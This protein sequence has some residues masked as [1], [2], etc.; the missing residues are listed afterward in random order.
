MTLVWPYTRAVLTN[1]ALWFWGVVFMAF[2]F[3]LGAYVFSG[4]LSPGH[5][6]EVA[7]TSAWFAVIALFSL[8]TLA[9]SMASSITYGTSALAFGFR[10]TRLTPARYTFALIVASAVM[11]VL[12]SFIMATAV[13]GLFSAHFGSMILPVDLPAIVG[14]A[15][16]SG[17]FMMGLATTLV[18]V[19]VNYLGLRNMNFIEFFPLILAY[20]FGFTQLF[21]SVPAWVLYLSPWNDMESLLYQAFSGSPARVVLGTATSPVLSWGVSAGALAAWVAVLVG[22]A[23]LLLARIHSVSI[24]EG[25]QI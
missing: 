7:Y 4:G 15:V 21:L 13:S 12:L 14:V 1:P 24:Q 11:A 22:V 6:A 3:V 18:L 17:A 5:S 20:I 25:R 16:L 10:F 9:M 19:V 23:S 2:W 8:T